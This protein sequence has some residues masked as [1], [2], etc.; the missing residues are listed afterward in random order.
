V[1]GSVG[2]PSSQSTV[3][4]CGKKL[5]W[6]HWTVKDWPGFTVRSGPQLRKGAG[7]EVPNG[8]EEGEGVGVGRDVPVGVGMAVGV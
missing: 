7:V 8:G 1:H 2:F 3:A 4:D 5:R 6:S